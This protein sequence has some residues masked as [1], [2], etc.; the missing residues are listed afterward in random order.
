MTLEIK[1][2][3]LF[4]YSIIDRLKASLDVF[5]VVKMNT[6][7]NMKKLLLAMIPVM[8]G[9]SS[10][11]GE[12]PVE[13][14]V[15][16]SDQSQ[17]LLTK[18]DDGYHV[19]D[20]I[21]GDSTIRLPA[22]YQENDGTLVPVT[23]ISAYG[24]ARRPQL[25]TVYLSPTIKFIGANAFYESSIE[26]LYVTPYLE[27]MDAEAFNG[28]GLSFVEK[29]SSYFLPTPSSDVGYLL[30]YSTNA[31]LTNGVYQISIPDGCQAIYKG[32][33]KDFVGQITLPDSI[34]V[35]G[36][37]AFENANIGYQADFSNVKHIGAKAFYNAQCLRYKKNGNA[38]Y[39]IHGYG[40]AF[41]SKLTTVGSSAFYGASYSRTYLGVDPFKEGIIDLGH[42]AKPT[43][44]A[45]DWNVNYSVNYLGS[46]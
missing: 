3:I 13:S 24:L 28:S 15:I 7:S 38:N 44:F 11:G 8:A 25:N 46:E 1:V 39:T 36:E 12:A 10:C 35:I 29:D 17:F 37:G 45:D 4:T 6:K 26:K 42:D 9:L 18:Y 21:G 22:Y 43:G 41:S 33:F 5:C 14:E 34:E 2:V 27:D 31:S 40:F 23:A 30:A 32:V 20:Y 16:A 19:D